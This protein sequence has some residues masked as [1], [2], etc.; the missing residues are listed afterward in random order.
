MKQGNTTV[1]RRRGFEANAAMGL[2]TRQRQSA[3][4]AAIADE[5]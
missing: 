3:G 5:G 1:I 4:M 2:M